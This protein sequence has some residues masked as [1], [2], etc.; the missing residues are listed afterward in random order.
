MFDVLTDLLTVLIQ[1]C[2]YPLHCCWPV[3]RDCFLNGL[4]FSISGSRAKCWPRPSF[5]SLCLCDG[6]RLVG[7]G[8][9][10]GASILSLLHGV[11]SITFRGNQL[12]SGVA[13]NF[14]AADDRIDRPKLV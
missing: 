10:I 6:K 9:G 8:C 4:E 13:I 7:V 3:W 11:A 2:A 1:P 5:C 14:L 12:I